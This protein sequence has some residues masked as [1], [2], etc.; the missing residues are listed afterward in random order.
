MC[1][2]A[3]TY[4]LAESS[5]KEYDKRR[6]MSCNLLNKPPPSFEWIFNNCKKIVLTRKRK[7]KTTLSWPTLSYF[8]FVFKVS[9]KLF[10]GFKQDI[11]ADLDFLGI[12][13]MQKFQNLFI[14]RNYDEKSI[15]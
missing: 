1:L 10:N 6:T 9:T 13:V 7:I 14:Q 8:F 15:S 12:I 2:K 4:R 11:F 3:Y 5:Q